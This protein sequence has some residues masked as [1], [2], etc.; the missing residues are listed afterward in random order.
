MQI[1][2]L[3]GGIR[4][5]MKGDKDHWDWGK[6]MVHCPLL[7]GQSTAVLRPQTRTTI[8]SLSLR[9]MVQPSCYI[10]FVPNSQTLGTLWTLVFCHLELFAL[11]I[12]CAFLS[13]LIST[14][15]IYFYILYPSSCIAQYLAYVGCWLIE[16]S[17]KILPFII[18][19]NILSPSII[20]CLFINFED[21]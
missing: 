13:S 15:F 7:P 20:K 1:H 9:L 21:H 5:L 10:D 11:T 19:Y 2:S 16:G 8:P 17:L 3:K 14:T 6:K 18:Y 4:T 12:I